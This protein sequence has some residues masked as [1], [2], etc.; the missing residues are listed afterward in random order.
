MSHYQFNSEHQDGKPTTRDYSHH[1]DHATAKQRAGK[2]AKLHDCQVDL[3]ID[4]S[5]PH[6]ERYLT[7]AMP[8][9]HHKTGYRLERL[10]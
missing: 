8:S 10:T 2:L 7:T 4:G 9:E 3:L 5:E 6:N 1:G